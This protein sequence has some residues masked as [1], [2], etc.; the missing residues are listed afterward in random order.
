VRNGPRQFLP[1]VAFVFS[2]VAPDAIWAQEPP[3]TGP[4]EIVP[5]TPGPPPKVSKPANPSGAT[6]PAAPATITRQEAAALAV[7]IAPLVEEIRGAKFKYPVPVEIVDDAGARRHFQGRMERYW[8]ATQMHAE[9]IVYAHLGLLP[10]QS[11]LAGEVYDVLEEQASGFYDPDRDTFFVL[12]DMPRS[13]APII[14]AHELTH[15]LDDQYFGIDALL[16]K[17][18]DDSDRAGAL[19]AV[20]EG[21]GTA[22]MSVFIVHQLQA[23][24]LDPHALVEFQ[25]SEAGQAARLK[26]TPLFVQRSLLAPYILGMAFLL[27]GE[28]IRMKTGGITPSDIDHAFSD[29][30]QSTEQILHPEKYWDP[31]RR[32]LPRRVSFPDLSGTLGPGWKRA[33]KGDLGEL[34]LALITGLDPGDPTSTDHPLERWTNDAASGWGGDLWHLYRNGERA[35]TVL[36]TVWDT[37]KDAREFASGLRL[38]AGARIKR[39]GDAVIVVAGDAEGKTGELLDRTLQAVR[40]GERAGG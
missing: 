22:V 10:P 9:E 5:P 31:A 32:D 24:K 7:E 8:P 1:V 27:R 17:T 6:T 33:E 36:A 29:P 26:A 40:S 35:V 20:V 18:G 3:E 38:P 11:D 39:K 25:H 2:L 4:S 16:A 15:A 21:S 34:T 13:I 23:G 19:D 30:P 12:G 28:M 37:E 14:T